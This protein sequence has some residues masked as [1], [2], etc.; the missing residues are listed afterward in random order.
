MR[1]TKQLQA[2]HPGEQAPIAFEGEVYIA[3][4]EY[5]EAIGAYD[6]ALAL[7]PNR[8]ISL[9]AHRLI[10]RTGSGDQFRPLI[11]HLDQRP[12]DLVARQILAQAYER[13]GQLDKAIKE[14][15]TVVA[16]EPDNVAV[17]N[18]LA[19]NYSQ[20]GDSRARSTAQRA[21]ELSPEDASIM[22]TLG[23]ILIE[24]GDLAEGVELLQEAVALNGGR[25]ELRYHLAVGLAKLDR[26]E[27]ARRTLEE[28]LQDDQ[29]FSS[30]SEAE[31]LLSELK[32]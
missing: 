3:K 24:E 26:K 5:A 18:N 7:G 12:L 16:A 32:P 22:D 10:Q 20:K 29:R 1:L 31:K 11:Q 9:R 25:P 27:E 2:A 23:W 17:L 6:R 28:I 21:Y 19:W 13:D 4:G 15:E 8:N 14:Y 30:R